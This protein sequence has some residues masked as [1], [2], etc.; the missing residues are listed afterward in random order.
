MLPMFTIR[1]HGEANHCQQRI[2][3]HLWNIIDINI[4]PAKLL[5]KAVIV[6]TN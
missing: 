3:E 2:Y 1:Y 5:L 6:L 4:R